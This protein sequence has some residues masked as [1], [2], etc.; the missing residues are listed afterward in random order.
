MAESYPEFGISRDELEQNIFLAYKDYVHSIEVAKLYSDAE[1]DLRD[2][3]SMLNKSSEGIRMHVENIGEF[4]GHVL[5]FG[6]KQERLIALVDLY[7]T[8]FPD[9]EM[10][11]I[12]LDK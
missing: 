4:Y 5:E 10:S 6:A 8:H 1:P 12:H 2:A 3:M 9:Q 7:D 11:T